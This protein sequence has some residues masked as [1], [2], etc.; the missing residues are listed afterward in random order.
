MKKARIHPLILLTAV[1]IS[2]LTGFYLGRNVNRSPVQI[3]QIA[4][5]SATV[6]ETVPETEP[7][8][9]QLQIVN[10]NTASLEQLQ[11]LPGIGPVY[12]QRII[13][14]RTEHGPFKSVGELMNVSGIGPK[15]LEEIWDY[16]TTGG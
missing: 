7:E 16:V 1:F 8:P 12:A 6:S 9:T 14:Y 13:D 4:A 2:L 11:T 15:R 10:I 5:P 3:Q